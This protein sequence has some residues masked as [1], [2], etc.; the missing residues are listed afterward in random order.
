VPDKT[1]KTYGESIA[2]TP[3]VPIQVGLWATIRK[4]NT[5]GMWGG[6]ITAVYPSGIALI[7]TLDSPGAEALWVSDDDVV[8]IPD[9]K[10]R[11]GLLPILKN[12]RERMG[13]SLDIS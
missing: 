7:V 12:Y 4:T 13:L 1:F 11:D 9:A 2:E 5:T 3:K 10:L 6:I 8:V